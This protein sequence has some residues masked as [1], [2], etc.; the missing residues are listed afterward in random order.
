MIK[1]RRERGYEIAQQDKPRY[2]DG[3]WL[4]RS[5][6]NPRRTYRVTL[7]LEGAIC[8]CDDYAIRHLKCV[9]L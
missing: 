1:E 6:T 5:Q 4:V 7:T 2:K 9:T 8:D 3:V